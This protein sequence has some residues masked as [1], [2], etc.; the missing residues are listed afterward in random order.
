MS[1][2]VQIAAGAYHNV[3]M[4][5]DGSVFVWGRNTEGEAGNGSSGANGLIYQLTPTRS[6]LGGK[7]IDIRA[8]GFHTLAR[9]TDGSI[10][11]WGSNS[12]GQI[13][14]GSINDTSCSCKAT[15][16]QSAVGTGNAI[17][18]A[19]G[20]HNF[21]IN[22]QIRMKFGSGTIFQGDNVRI[23]FEG[24]MGAGMTVYTAINPTEIN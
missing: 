16:V 1:N 22:P 14:D 24:V 11:A 13:G 10:F 18:G 8:G 23:T 7:V 4:K 2:V 5:D 9:K 3:A 21:A 20:F 6:E 17:F 12:F 15:P 19:G